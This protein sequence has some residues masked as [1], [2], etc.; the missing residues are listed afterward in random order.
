ME[1]WNITYPGRPVPDQMSQP[2]CAQFALSRDRIQATPLAQYIFYR[3]WLLQTELNDF[4]SGRTWEYLWHF[5][6]TRKTVLCPDEF[7]CYCDGYGICF[8]GSEKLDEWFSISKRKDNIS[9]QLSLLRSS[10]LEQD[11]VSSG[12]SDDVEEERAMKDQMLELDIRRYKIK[13]AAFERGRNPQMRAEAAGRT[14]KDGD[15]Y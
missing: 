14:W 13:E 10:K 5:V 8:D 7:V 6:F 4:G 2:C 1:F 3:D 11:N 12:A 15:G 9:E